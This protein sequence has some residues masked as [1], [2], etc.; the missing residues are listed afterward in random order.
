MRETAAAVLA[1]LLLAAASCGGGSGNDTQAPTTSA[2]SASPAS[3]APE[4]PTPIRTSTPLPPRPEPT[5]V[6]STEP[7]FQAIAGNR[8]F[9]PTIAE[10]Q[11]LPTATVAG[12]TGVTL[13]EV[14]RRVGAGAGA[15]VTVSGYR[16]GAGTTVFYRTSL[17]EAAESTVLVLA[18]SGHVAFAMPEVAESQWIAAVDRI[19]FE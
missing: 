13:G 17:D 3:G 18:E 6:P 2:A 4:E 5:P 8:E 9:A 19:V 12:R 11:R 10:F 7:L 14:A 1:A 15:T 16:S